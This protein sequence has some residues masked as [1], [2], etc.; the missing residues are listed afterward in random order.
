MCRAGAKLQPCFDASPGLDVGDAVLDSLDD[1][2]SADHEPGAVQPPRRH[3]ARDA[4]HLE[5][6]LPLRPLPPLPPLRP[7]PPFRPLAHLATSTSRPGFR[8]AA[9]TTG[10]A[11]A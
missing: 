11:L 4:I 1:D 5:F 2:L 8:R 10:R 6:D 7:P 9:L 3:P